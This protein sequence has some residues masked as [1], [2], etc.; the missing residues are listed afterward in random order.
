MT[1]DPY[2]LT[3]RDPLE[4][5]V[6]D[7][8]ERTP[9]LSRRQRRTVEACALLVLAPGLLAVRWID[10]SHQAVQ[11]QP[12]ERVTVVRR[13][14]TGTL[15]HVR[16]R[17]VGRDATGALKT[18]TTPAGAARV[19]LVLEVRALDAQGAKDAKYIGYAL[20]DRSGHVWMALGLP[21]GDRDPVVGAPA[22]VTVS[23]TLPERLLS[24]VVLEARQGSPA[25]KGTGPVQVLRFAH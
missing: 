9:R 6:P 8:V 12:D 3:T 2:E 14:A 23:A 5:T 16:L 13:G 10:D 20:R 4:D 11:W 24:S 21:E 19:A 25:R 18:R 15:E 1:L 17:L 22:R 7:P